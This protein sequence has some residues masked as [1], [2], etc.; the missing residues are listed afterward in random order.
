MQAV[1][2]SLHAGEPETVA[3]GTSALRHTLIDGAKRIR[4]GGTAVGTETLHQLRARAPQFSSE[5]MIG[6]PGET[7]VCRPVRGKLKAAGS[8]LLDLPP[9]QMVEPVPGVA[10]IPVVCLADVIGDQKR[11]GREAEVGENR[12]G[13]LGEGGVTVVECQ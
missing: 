12:V 2:I 4:N 6:Q 3:G 11:R 7:A 5:I 9:G 8:P 10:H 1:A 13:V